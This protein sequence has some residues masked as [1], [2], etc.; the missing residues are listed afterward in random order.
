M[1]RSDRAPTGLMI[2]E[3]R[4]PE[5]I[6]VYYY[7]HGSAAAGLSEADV[8]E[9]LVAGAGHVHLTGITLALGDGPAAA[10]RKT[11]SIAKANEV[12][13]SFDP[14][15]RRKLWGDGEAV[16]AYE[17]IGEDVDDLLISRHEASVCAGTADLDEAI[18]YLAGF[19]IP[20]VAL[21]RG[22]RGVLGIADGERHEM[23]AHPV[24]SV[25]DTV[26]AGDA[27]NAGYLHGRISGRSFPEALDCGNWVA[28]RVIAH[29]GD[30]EGLPSRQEYDDHRDDDERAPR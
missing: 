23:A 3:A 4:S 25:V 12:P 24:G 2:K 30:Y 5:D 15:L 28:S 8:P 14:N 27:F 18:D 7:R 19:G 1:T 9:D 29:A 22:A 20:R 13:V 21:R 11:L 6:H 17:E 10:L 16:A 26:G